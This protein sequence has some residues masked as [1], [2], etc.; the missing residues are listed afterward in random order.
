MGGVVTYNY[1]VYYYYDGV[2]D[3]DAR[4]EGTGALGDP[5]F[6]SAADETVHDGKNYVLDRVENK[7]GK[8]GE[9]AGQNVVKVYYALVEEEEQEVKKPA[10]TLTA[11]AVSITSSGS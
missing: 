11:V 1:V 3:E 9:D 7:D 4:A 6:T 5:I 2:E 10:Q 8:I